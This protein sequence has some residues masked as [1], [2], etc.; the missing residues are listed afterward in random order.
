MWQSQI[1]IKYYFVFRASVSLSLTHYGTKLLLGARL[2]HT[3][4]MH[5]IFIHLHTTIQRYSM[6]IKLGDVLEI[7]SIWD[8][9]MCNKIK[10]L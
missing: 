10:I 7:R 9:H 4:W 1:E 2:V 6:C 8:C 5:Q 3:S